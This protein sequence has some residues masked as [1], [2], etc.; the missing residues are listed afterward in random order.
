MSTYT[1]LAPYVRIQSNLDADAFDEFTRFCD[2]VLSLKKNT[3]PNKTQYEKVIRQ[4]KRHLK[5]RFGKIANQTTMENM[6]SVFSTILETSMDDVDDT[7]S[8]I[9]IPITRTLES[10]TKSM[11]D[12]QEMPVVK[13]EQIVTKE[14]D[15]GFLCTNVIICK[16]ASILLCKVGEKY[17]LPGGFAKFNESGRNA[18]IRHLKEQCQITSITGSELDILDSYESKETNPSD[19]HMIVNFIYS[20]KSKHYVTTTNKYNAGYIDFDKVFS[21]NLYEEDA[22]IIKHFILK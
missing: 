21:L 1:K 8:C 17:F 19:R 3:K 4:T 14:N 16:A 10:T 22:K 5:G 9:T 6:M 12:T 15:E 13:E 11:S 7:T 2:I 18:V 20:G